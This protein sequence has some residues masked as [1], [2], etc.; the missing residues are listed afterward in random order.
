MT[1]IS[2]SVACTALDVTV[3]FNK[4]ELDAP[5]RK[6]TIAFEGHSNSNCKI[7]FKT[8]SNIQGEYIWI[9]AAYNECGIRASEEGTNIVYAQTLVVTY[10]NNLTNNTFIQGE[11]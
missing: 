10:G 11:E 9:Q 7:N 1:L 5:G 6:Y 8:S 2:A 3:T 4:T